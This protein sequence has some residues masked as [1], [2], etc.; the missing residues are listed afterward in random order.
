[1]IY[2]LPWG[3]HSL[4]QLRLDI[5]TQ[6]MSQQVEPRVFYQEWV[7]KSVYVFEV[8]PPGRRWKGVFLAETDPN[9]TK[10]QVTVADWG[11]IKVDPA[12]ERVVLVPP[13]TVRHTAT[14]NPPL[15]SDIT[16]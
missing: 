11:E 15:T 10:T 7:G 16:P 3:N 12:G 9:S 6:T 4:Q 8:P 13:N 2:I 14:L 1:M 5:L